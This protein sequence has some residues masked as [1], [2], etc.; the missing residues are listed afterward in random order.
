MLI[1]LLGGTSSSLVKKTTRNNFP[2]QPR[3]AE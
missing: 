1:D 2:H 3:V